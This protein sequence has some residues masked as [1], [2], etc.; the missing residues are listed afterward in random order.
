[1]VGGVMVA[2]VRKLLFHLMVKFDSTKE[3]NQIFQSAQKEFRNSSTFINFNNF[4]SLNQS[5][6]ASTHRHPMMEEISLAHPIVVSPRECT[7]PLKSNKK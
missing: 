2:R 1:M 6:I 5:Q 3:S 7:Q 4:Q